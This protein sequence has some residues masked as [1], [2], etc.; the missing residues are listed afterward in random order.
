MNSSDGFAPGTWKVEGWMES[1]GVSTR[2]SPGAVTAETVEVTPA[3]AAYPP[4]SLFFSQ[5]YHGEKDWSGVSFD[6]GKVSGSLH[7]GQS[8]VPLTGIYARDHFRVA[9]GFGGGVEQVVEGKLVEPA[10]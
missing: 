5:F 10:S 8:D 6:S 1:G 2:D 9:L 7:H 3:Q 4:A